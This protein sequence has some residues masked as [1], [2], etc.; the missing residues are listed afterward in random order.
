V[1]VVSLTVQVTVVSTASTGRT[2]A[3]N[4]L[5]ASSYIE[6]VVI[7][8]FTLT[9]S[10]F[11]V[12]R[13]TVNSTALETILE[14]A[15]EVAVIDVVPAVRHVTTPS[16]TLATSGCVEAQVTVFNAPFGLTSRTNVTVLSGINVSIA[17][18]VEIEIDVG[19]AF[20]TSAAY[21]TT[22]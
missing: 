7:P 5:T 19:F 22:N 6:Y 20:T 4:V 10:A 11:A 9:L 15:V 17:S 1:P 13:L 12:G 18:V 8:P 2:S 14:L 21:K 16:L 3:V